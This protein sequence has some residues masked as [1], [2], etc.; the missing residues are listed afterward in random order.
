MR[1]TKW[2]G[3]ALIAA[4]VMM[5]DYASA[6]SATPES[7]IVMP[8]R[9]RVV[10]TG[11]QLAH[12]KNIGLVTYNNSSLLA[13][14]LIHIWN[15]QEWIQISTEDFNQGSFMSG[16]PKRIFIL[17]ED[18]GIPSQL[19]VPPSWCKETH[20]IS[21]LDTTALINQIGTVLK[22]SSRQWKWLADING[23][24]AT[25]R[26]T[27]R[28]RYGRWGAP[29]KEKDL[30]PTRLESIPLP[31]A[32]I[33]IEPKTEFEPAPAKIA[34]AT[35]TPE[36]VVLPVAPAAESAPV[37]VKHKAPAPKAPVK[38]ADAPKVE[39]AKTDVK[40]EAPKAPAKAEANMTEAAVPAL[41]DVDADDS[42]AP[43]P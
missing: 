3:S 35:K 20:R 6:G 30:A 32:P 42:E 39:P 12:C 37:T 13:A 4:A 31:P 43:A 19:T 23:L 22:L 2:L 14:P 36:K 40:V 17:G 34:P 5:S 28:R 38:K 10:Q 18:A 11:F 15:G 9:K 25:D 41:D 27:E 24:S 21:T 16:E 8:A 33:M 26:N 1:M 29:G 7:I